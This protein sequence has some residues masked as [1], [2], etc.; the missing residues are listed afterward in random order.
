[1]AEERDG[2]QWKQGSSGL[3]QA[4]RQRQERDRKQ[5]Q[6]GR[7]IIRGEDVKLE[8]EEKNGIWI[9]GL[10]STEMGFDNR[11]IEVDCHI[12]PPHT[13]SVTH[14]HNEAVLFVLRGSGYTLLDGERVDWGP[15]DT[16]YIAAG[17]WHQ[18]HVTSDEPAMVLAIKPI[19]LQEYLGELNIVYKGDAPAISH[20]YKPG[21]FKEEFGRVGSKNNG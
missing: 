5:R 9:G 2:E 4:R 16:V 13:H 3:F 18:H 20:E 15:G 12:Y 21:S 8:W 1:M 10:V 7:K 17:L 19:P 14:K 6:A 11:T